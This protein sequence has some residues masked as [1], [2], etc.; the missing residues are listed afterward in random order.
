MLQQTPK[1][2]WTKI[3]EKCVK[4]IH[5]LVIKPSQIREIIKL[6]YA[7][8][9]HRNNLSL[10]FMKVN[11]LKWIIHTRIWLAIQLNFFPISIFLPVSYWI[12]SLINYLFIFSYVIIHP[13]I[14][15]YFFDFLYNLELGECVGIVRNFTE[16]NSR[17]GLI[18]LFVVGARPIYSNRWKTPPENCDTFVHARLGS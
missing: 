7:C 1:D 14:Y 9:I 13:F 17:N 12:K 15:S 5:L 8:Y 2:V 18:K 6:N 3:A 11:V 16:D 4:N 10:S